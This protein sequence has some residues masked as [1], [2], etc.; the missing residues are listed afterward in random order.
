MEQYFFLSHISFPD[1]PTSTKGLTFKVFPVDSGK[2]NMEFSDSL[3]EVSE[4][5]FWPNVSKKRIW[6]PQSHPAEGSII[7][8]NYSCA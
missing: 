3:R 8:T 5:V 4:K 2:M 1:L 7:F 6:Q